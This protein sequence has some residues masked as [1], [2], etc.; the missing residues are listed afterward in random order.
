MV[1]HLTE[2]DRLKSEIARLREALKR[3]KTNCERYHVDEAVHDAELERLRAQ[4]IP[5]PPEVRDSIESLGDRPMVV[6]EITDWQYVNDMLTQAADQRDEYREVLK[7]FG[8]RHRPP[9]NWM[10]AKSVVC[11]ECGGDWPCQTTRIVSNALE[12]T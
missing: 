6:A 3:E 10:E 11:V 4:T 9:D 7:G 12:E 1:E 8:R 2:A 5:Y